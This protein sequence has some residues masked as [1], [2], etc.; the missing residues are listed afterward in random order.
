MQYEFGKHYQMHLIKPL[1]EALAKTSSTP[2]GKVLDIFTK[3]LELQAGQQ[4][5]GG[6]T[7]DASKAADPQP[8]VEL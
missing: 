6:K 5:K 7:A 3:Q 1:K 8:K 2:C 4:L